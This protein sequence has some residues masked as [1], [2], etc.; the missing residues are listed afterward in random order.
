[1]KH[2]PRED[3][4]SSEHRHARA[5]WPPPAGRAGVTFTSEVERGGCQESS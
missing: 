4:G 3:D 5:Q 1:M 2:D